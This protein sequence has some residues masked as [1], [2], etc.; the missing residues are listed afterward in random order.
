MVADRYKAVD[1]YPFPYIKYLDYQEGQVKDDGYNFTTYE[2]PTQH[3]PKGIIYYVPDHGECGED[4][5]YLFKRCNALGLRVF[6]MDQKGFGL[7]QGKRGSHDPR[8]YHN[9]WNFIHSVGFLKGFQKNLPKF[10][11]GQGYGAFQA[12]RLIQQNP[13]FFSGAILVNPLYEFKHKLGTFAITKLRAQ[14]LLNPHGIF[15]IEGL[16]ESKEVQGLCDKLSYFDWQIGILNQTMDEQFEA[17]QK[18]NTIEKTPILMILSEENDYINTETARKAFNDI[19][20]QDKKIQTFH[21]THHYMLWLD[22]EW[23]RAEQEMLAWLS[24]RVK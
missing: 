22:K 20:I 12:T 9:I 8:V 18:M 4:K 13:D 10:I 14:G 6:S 3:N 19:K 7:S 11:F 5:G 2:Y 21:D 15:P 16:R 24:P 1:R 23:Q 17:V